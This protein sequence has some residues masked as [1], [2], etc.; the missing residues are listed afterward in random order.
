MMIDAAR[1]ITAVN[2][3]LAGDTG[4]KGV[5]TATTTLA[6]IE[7]GLKVFTAI[8]KRVYRSLKDEF[9][10]LF[11]L[12]AR[13]MDDQ[14]Y[15]TVLDDPVAI[16][17]SDYDGGS[18]DV[19]PVADPRLV[20][21]MQKSARANVIMQIAGHPTLG[22]VQNPHEALK[23]IYDSVGI[24]NQERLIVPPQPP[25]PLVEANAVAEVKGKEAKAAKD[26]AQADKYQREAESV[27]QQEPGGP[28]PLE[29][30]RL[31][32]D[33]DERAERLQMDVA[34]M[35]HGQQMAEAKAIL[36]DQFRRDKLEADAKVKKAEGKRAA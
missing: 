11:E 21:D 4:D 19:A 1:D 2:D 9:K 25:N 23:M 5:Q 14:E 35:E 17:K 12:N 26:A 31:E 28:D 18:M 29:I 3:I 34:D 15:F 22:A 20:T 32:L 36:D 16:A 30:A 10:L 7:Q 24:E 13:Y 6:L 33:Q 27:T 8:Y